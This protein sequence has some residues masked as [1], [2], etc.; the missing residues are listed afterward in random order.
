MIPMHPVRHLP[1]CAAVLLGAAAA[2][3]AAT[4]PVNEAASHAGQTVTVQGVVGEVASGPAGATYI[5]LDGRYPDN[6]FTAVVLSEGDAGTDAWY[7]LRGRTADITGTVEM[8]D[9]KPE[10]VATSTQDVRMLP[11]RRVRIAQS[12]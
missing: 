7:G 6:A 3:V 4:I 10:I 2:A 1:I 8:V 9:G 11:A 5:D 12:R